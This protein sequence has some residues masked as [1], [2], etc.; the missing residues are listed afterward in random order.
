ME[1]NT[2]V[3]YEKDLFADYDNFDYQDFFDSLENPNRFEDYDFDYQDF[4][5]DIL[6]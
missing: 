6:K 4:F 3:F 5:K 1:N 2:D